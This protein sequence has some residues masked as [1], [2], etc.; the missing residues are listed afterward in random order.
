MSAE[1]DAHL[2]AVLIGGREERPIVVVDYNDGWPARFERLAD[3]V[4]DALGD[5]ALT[6]EHIGSTAVPGLAAKPVIDM[7]LIVTDVA[8][9]AA[10]VPPLEA[11]G[12]ARLP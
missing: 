6:V 8:D 4:R 11:Q 7:L 3:R 9:E 1:T 12:L 5:A 10:Y 2:D